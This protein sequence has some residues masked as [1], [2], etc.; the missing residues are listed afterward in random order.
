MLSWPPCASYAR[1]P[2][3]SLPRRAYLSLDAAF[4]RFFACL[5]R[6]A[7]V[8]LR[9][10]RFQLRIQLA[11]RQRT[12]RLP[13][14]LNIVKRTPLAQKNMHHKSRRNPAEPSRPCACPHG[15][16]VRRR[17]PFQSTSSHRRSQW[18]GDRSLRG[19]QE[20]IRPIPNQ[21]GS[22][23]RMRVSTPF[24]S[25][26]LS[27]CLYKEACCCR[28]SVVVILEQ[29]FSSFNRRLFARSRASRNHR[30]PLT[31]KAMFTNVSQHCVR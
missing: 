25:H 29:W 23:S 20:K 19:D 27:R 6:A 4:A 7:F 8:F 26:R 5:S 14:A 2:P 3:S 15:S 24:F 9:Q 12:C 17:T 16:S 31:I 1:W 13:Q 28:T 11:R 30:L 18:L 21:W 22:S 10:R